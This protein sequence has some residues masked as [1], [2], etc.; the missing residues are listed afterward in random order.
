MAGTYR[1]DTFPP[2]FFYTDTR[3]KAGKDLRDRIAPDKADSAEHKGELWSGSPT[4]AGTVPAAKIV[5]FLLG[6]RMI[7]PRRE[8]AVI[9]RGEARKSRLPPAARQVKE[10]KYAFA[11]WL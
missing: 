10:L 3:Q 9:R 8:N 7:L 2:C 1:T 5:L 4:Q 6:T 11:A